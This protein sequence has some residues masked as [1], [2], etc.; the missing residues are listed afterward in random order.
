MPEEQLF[1]ESIVKL[2]KLA[3]TGTGAVEIKSGYGL[4][5]A[6][7][8]KMLRVIKQLKKLSPVTC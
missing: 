2:D 3:A 1:E 8:L 4:T 7:E 6:S 5:V